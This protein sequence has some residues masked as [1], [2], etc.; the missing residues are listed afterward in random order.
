LHILEL[1]GSPLERGRVHGEH[2]REEIRD[3]IAWF[4]HLLSEYG[5]V[6]P[7][8]LFARLTAL[9]W[10]AAIE[11]WTSH[12]LEEMR[13][14]AEGSGLPYLDILAWNHCQEIFWAVFVEHGFTQSGDQL[15]GCSTVG[16][17][18]DSHHPT[19]LAQNAD[20][21]PFWHGHQTVLRFCE[22]GSDVEE[23]LLSYPG[24]V[25]IYGLNSL[26]IGL[27]VNAMFYRLN[28]SLRGLGTPFIA[29]G[30]L[31]KRSY[32]EAERFLCSVPHASGNTLTLAGP[33]NATAYEVSANQIRAFRPSSMPGRT[34]HTNHEL[35]N[36]DFRPGVD[37]TPDQ[38]S[39]ERIKV[40][41]ESL[42]QTQ[43]PLT[44]SDIKTILRS[45]GE[46]NQ[47]AFAPLCRH[48]DDP[49]GSMTT[50]SVIME[51]SE[52]PTLRVS[53]GPPCREE[54][55]TFEFSVRSSF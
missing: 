32:Q 34:Y 46:N 21:T 54:Y 27:C 35:V 42:K 26:G 51:C 20:T 40:L 9:G 30:V 12:L 22:T 48:E 19:L 23:I 14:I 2:L 15:S 7:D 10:L 28:N 3:Q 31:A 24:L 16:D 33:D 44:A 18:G 13:G 36:D 52:H 39:L 29:R 6:N 43:D 50:Y 49:F 5:Q 47:G 37:R 53:F 17:V 25:G 38:N 4:R 41:E 11:Q 8:E 45:H 55:Q 1:S